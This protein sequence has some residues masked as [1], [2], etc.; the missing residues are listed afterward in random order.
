MKS[1]FA[2]T[3]E[4]FESSSDS[5]FDNI[6]KLIALYEAAGDEEGE[7][8]EG[9][10]QGGTQEEQPVDATEPAPEQADQPAEE[11]SGI[12]ISSNQK[13]VL[14]KTMLDALMAQPP[15]AGEIP[16]ELTN[17]SD[18]NADQVIKFIQSLVSLSTSLDTSATSDATPNSLASELKNIR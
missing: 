12:Y 11:A 9:A 15:K 5:V 2:K 8:A 6:D 3:T 18:N 1:I 10:E 14:A 17:V 16:D 13:A 4:I 7:D